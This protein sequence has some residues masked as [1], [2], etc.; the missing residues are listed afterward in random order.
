[1]NNPVADPLTRINHRVITRRS[2][3]CG[4]REHRMNNPVA[5]SAWDTY[6]RID[7]TVLRELLWLIQYRH[8]IHRPA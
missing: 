1:M 7:H 6:H 8:S 2:R 5:D 3:S 4:A